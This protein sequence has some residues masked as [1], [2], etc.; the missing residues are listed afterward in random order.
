MLRYPIDESYHTC[1]CCTQDIDDDDDGNNYNI[2]VVFII[3]VIMIN[4]RDIFSM[5]RRT[6]DNQRMIDVKAGNTD[7]CRNC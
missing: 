1:C 3:M 5:T 7:G 4:D 2:F 6:T